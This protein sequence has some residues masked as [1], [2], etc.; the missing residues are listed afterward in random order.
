MTLFLLAG[1]IAKLPVVTLGGEAVAQVKDI[2]FEGTS[3]RVAG[4]TLSGR[5]LFAGP[6]KQGLPWSGVHAL[7]R[8]AVMVADTDR[9][10]PRT[11]VVATSQAQEGD[12][13]GS[14]VLTD[15]GVDLGEVVDVVIAVGATA[16]V[17]GYRIAANRPDDRRTRH[18]LVPAPETLAVSGEA[19]IV[20]AAA[21]DAMTEELPEFEAALRTFRARLGGDA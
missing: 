6:L 16:E 1:E 21:A 10:E 4:L 3:G 11:E 7:G 9:F 13:L 14:R 5:G 15:K 18:L 20:P 12:V 2:V 17:V 19:L 8:D